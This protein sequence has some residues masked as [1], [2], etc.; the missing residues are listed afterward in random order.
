MDILVAKAKA[1]VEVK[2]L[3]DG[4]G[5]LHTHGRF[6]HPLVKAG[7]QFA[8]FLPIL[9][10]PFRGRTNLRNHRKM[11]IVDNRIVLAG[12]F[13]TYISPR[14]A[15]VL[16][17]I[18]DA[19]L[20]RVTAV[21]NAAGDDVT[22]TGSIAGN[23]LFKQGGDRTL[24]VASHASAGG[25]DLTLKVSADGSAWRE[26]FSV[27][28]P[29]DYLVEKLDQSKAY[30]SDRKEEVGEAASAAKDAYRKAKEQH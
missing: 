13:G 10:R 20:D 28:V 7:G 29:K 5:T 21:G 3:M 16:G 9:H 1:G 30:L 18:P 26:V 2:L 14:H 24:G 23:V 8:F 27:D 12:A 17:M 19:P 15:M 25:D 22:F 6:F 4:V 11:T